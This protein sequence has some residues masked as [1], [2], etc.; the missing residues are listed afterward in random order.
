MSKEIPLM[1]FTIAGPMAHFRKFYTNTSALTYPFPP[2]TTLMGLVAG[3]LGRKKDSYYE[4]LSS[5]RLWIGVRI[6]TPIRI[7]TYTVNYLFTKGNTLYDKGMGTQIPMGWVLPREPFR[8]L[9]YRVYLSTPDTE[10]WR[11]I[12]NVFSSKKFCWPPYL[13]ISEAAAWIEPDIWIGKTTYRQKDDYLLVGT[14]IILHS[15]M[16]LRL[17]DNRPV[18]LLLDKFTLDILPHPYRSTEKTVEILYEKD[19][20]P[21]W[22]RLPYPVFLL[23]DTKEENIFGTF[24]TEHP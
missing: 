11:E 13:G 10:L 3:L 17:D 20:K 15:Q 4:S 1:A 14:P 19:G 7:R 5:E 21:F 6:C 18:K 23:P 12:I 16:E 22:V 2:R 9:R 8:V 24:F